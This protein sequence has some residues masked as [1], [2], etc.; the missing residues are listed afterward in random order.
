MAYD[1]TTIPAMD[2]LLRRGVFIAQIYRRPVTATYRGSTYT[3]SRTTP[4]ASRKMALSGF[5]QE[6]PDLEIMI[7][8]SIGAAEPVPLGSDS[9]VIEGKTY[10]I[11]AVQADIAPSCY[12]LTLSLRRT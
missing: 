2:G 11:T 12:Q 6:V 8:L 9:V 5:T 1:P 7:S 3:V 10:R 4:S